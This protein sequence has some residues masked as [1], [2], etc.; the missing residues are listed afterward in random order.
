MV[1]ILTELSKEAFYQELMQCK[2]TVTKTLPVF[3]RQAWLI[4]KLQYTIGV[5]CCGFEPCLSSWSVF[6]FSSLT[7]WATEWREEAD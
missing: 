1:Q 5:S 2:T 4:I 6:F 3:D 7:A